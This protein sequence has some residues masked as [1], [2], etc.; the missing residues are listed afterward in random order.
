MT[1]AAYNQNMQ[2]F[3]TEDHVV[4]LNE[5]VHDSRIIPLDGRPRPGIESWTGESR[6][7]WEGDTLVVETVD[8]SPKHG[9]RGYDAGSSPDRA[10]HARGCRDAALRVHDHG[11]GDVD[12]PL[13]GR[14]SDA[15]E[16]ATALRVCLPR[17]ELLD[18]RHL[19]GRPRGR[20]RGGVTGGVAVGPSGERRES[21]P[22]NG[23]D[24]RPARLG[25]NRRLQ[26]D[27]NGRVRR[28]LSGWAG[29]VV[30]KGGFEPP[31]A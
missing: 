24:S 8:F 19:G 7:R 29:K 17:G 1:P 27:R 28:G 14:S 13:D 21:A 6:G 3:Q 31:R 30:R 9:W 5:M 10:V 25:G 26:R 16:S 20:A 18:A 23:A 22:W 4:V 11:S 12:R 15:A 2:L